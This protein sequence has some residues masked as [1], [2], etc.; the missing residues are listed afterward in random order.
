MRIT[1]TI[2]TIIGVLTL[3]TCYGVAQDEPYDLKQLKARIGTWDSEM[4]VKPAAWTPEGAH[5]ECV[6]VTQPILKGRFIRSTYSAGDYEFLAVATYDAKEKVY[7][8]WMYDSMG[9][10]PK[11][12][13]CG[14]WNATSRT[15]DWRNDQGDGTVST[16]KWHFVDDDHFQWSAVVKDK[17]GKVCLDLEG[18]GTRRK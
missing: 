14:K 7:R 17:D 4:T 6:V 12:D 18:K 15:I 5:L 1:A 16:S 9:A 8:L 3:T 2:W 13:N 10:F 11:G